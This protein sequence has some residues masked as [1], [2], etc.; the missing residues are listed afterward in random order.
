MLTDYSLLITPG[1]VAAEAIDRNP[2]LLLMFEHLEI[3][4]G[5]Q[6][7]TIAQVCQETGI[8][9]NLF[10]IIARLFNGIHPNLMQLEALNGDIPLI[11]RYLENS[12]RNYITEKFPLLTILINDICKVNIHPEVELLKR[13]LDDYLDEV[14]EH[15]KY[16]NTVVFPYVL[17]LSGNK[18]PAAGMALEEYSMSEYRRHHDDIEEKLADL[19]NLL[20]KYL[21]AHNDIHFRRKL[22]LSLDELEFDLHIH[23]LIEENVLIPIVENFEKNNQPKS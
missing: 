3:P 2:R 23:S 14:A 8:D 22:L 11:I 18:L 4:L 1:T 9:A 12:H 21:P 7:K 13:F 20:I 5:L 19:K 6:D 10:L 17:A 15:L 16:E